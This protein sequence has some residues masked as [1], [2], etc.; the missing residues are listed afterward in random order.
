MEIV[1]RQ[2]NVEPLE[3]RDE[4]PVGAKV[5]EPS[6]ERAEEPPAVERRGS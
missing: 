2:K 5:V 4:E 1:W 6:A 3:V